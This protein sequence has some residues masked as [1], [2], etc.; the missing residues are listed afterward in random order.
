MSILA[1]SILSI[2]G[3]VENQ[4][5]SSGWKL[6][7]SIELDPHQNSAEID[8]TADP[9][10]SFQNCT[11]IVFGL[12]FKNKAYINNGVSLIFN[13]IYYFS[14]MY[15]PSANNTYYADSGTLIAT[16]PLVLYT[17]FYD[18][19]AD[20]FDSNKKYSMA[21]AKYYYY[22]KTSGNGVSRLSE[23][24]TFRYHQFQFNKGDVLGV[25]M[26]QYINLPF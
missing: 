5:S 14:S 9:S 17:S 15:G 20:F 16:E 25:I 18:S 11:F 23:P 2:P 1:E 22:S 13:D 19:E 6:I 21:N 8:L 26:G 4:T 7:T 12:Y 10:I 3:L 24:V